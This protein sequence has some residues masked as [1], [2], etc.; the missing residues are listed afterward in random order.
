MTLPEKMKEDVISFAKARGLTEEEAEALLRLAEEYYATHQL[1]P[2]E[3]A[4]IVTAQS[5][6]SLPH[7]LR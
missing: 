7:R 2:W 5:W 1:D 3:A 4:G 6:A